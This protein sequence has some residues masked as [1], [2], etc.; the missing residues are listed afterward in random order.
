VT[1]RPDRPTSHL[2]LALAALC[3]DCEMI[4]FTCLAACPAC[5]GTTLVNLKRLV[6]KEPAIYASGGTS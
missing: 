6:N 4:C 1:A 3:L 2:P 5:A